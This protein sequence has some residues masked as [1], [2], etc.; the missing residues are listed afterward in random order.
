MRSVFAIFLLAFSLGLPVFA[1]DMDH[2]AVTGT[3]AVA[4]NVTDQKVQ[5]GMVV[6]AQVVSPGPGWIVLHQDE[7]GKPGPVL[8]YA[9][10]KAGANEQVMVSVGEAL[11]G[12]KVWAMLHKD[13][14]T[15][16]TYEFPGADAPV[17]IQ[18]ALVP[19]TVQ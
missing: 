4:V 19:F 2:D 1:Q 15:L 3:G 9:P 6:L 10:V 7:A 12:S 5:D 18:G 13:A 17:L 14:G 8:G 11:S 16:G